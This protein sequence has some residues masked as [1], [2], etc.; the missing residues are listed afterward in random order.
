MK[1]KSLKR[2][3]RDACHQALTFRL[4]FY[5]IKGLRLVKQQPAP[6]K[7]RA[8]VNHTNLFM[9]Q[10]FVNVENKNFAAPRRTPIH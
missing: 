4:S 7:N 8:E 6:Q 1:K 3:S 9:D 5:D 2:L 10:Q